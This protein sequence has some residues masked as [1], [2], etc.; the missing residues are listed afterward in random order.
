MNLICKKSSLVSL[1]PM[2]VKPN[3][4]VVFKRDV[5]INCPFNSFGFR[6]NLK[7]F[8]S[9]AIFVVFDVITI[10]DCNK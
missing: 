5:S 6:V 3:P 7:G 2:I 4:C 1:A 9:V 10:P 8:C